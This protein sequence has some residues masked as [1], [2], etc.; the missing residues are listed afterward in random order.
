MV[1]LNHVFSIIFRFYNIN[2]FVHGVAGGQQFVIVRST[3]LEH[4]L[5][6]KLGC[7]DITSDN[8]ITAFKS[9]G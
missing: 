8:S 7:K 5:Q 4:L 9:P 1:G 6:Y 2:L 3:Q